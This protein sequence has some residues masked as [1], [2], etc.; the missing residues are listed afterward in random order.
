M[1]VGSSVPNEASAIQASRR[2]AT[3]PHLA[4][5]PG[6][7]TTAKDFL[8]LLETELGI[9][10]PS[11]QPIFAAGSHE[12]QHATLSISKTYEPRAWIDTYY[13]VMNTPLERTLQIV[14]KNGSVIWQADLIETADETDPEAAKYFDAVPIF[15][16]LS[17]G[18][19]VTGK[20]VDGNYC[21]KDVSSFSSMPWLHQISA[22]YS[23][24]STD[25]WQLVRIQEIILTSLSN[26][27][28]ET[29]LKGSIVMCR[30]GG[31]FRGLKVSFFL[32]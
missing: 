17:R 15:H 27:S 10:P 28:A 4:G 12:S 18:G 25:S 19:D 30:Y 26:C 6:D 5:T 31:I 14:D 7:L 24:I 8:Q 29:N 21:T 3:K 23:R 11:T 22:F 32:I 1:L 20:L 9:Q 13:P 2:F 16:G